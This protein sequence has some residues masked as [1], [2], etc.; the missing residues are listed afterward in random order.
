LPKDADSSFKDVSRGASFESVGV[1]PNPE[2]EWY[3]CSEMRP[4]EALLVKIHDSAAGQPQSGDLS[5]VI[6]N[7][8]PHT[9]LQI[10]GTEDVEARESIELR[11]LVF[12]D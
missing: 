11:C 6:A 3:Y 5:G 2:H 8:V 9:S 7:G 4:D 10:P 1:K 12:W